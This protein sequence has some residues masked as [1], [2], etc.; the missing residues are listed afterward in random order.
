MSVMAEIASEGARVIKTV[1]P[2]VL[3]LPLPF[4]LS[5]SGDLPD[6]QGLGGHR[7][8]HSA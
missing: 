2:I 6:F 7:E 5:A 3:G 1:Y 4:Q 8:M